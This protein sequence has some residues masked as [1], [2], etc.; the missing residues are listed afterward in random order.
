MPA[1]EALLKLSPAFG[2]GGA[3]AAGGGA[4][5]KDYEADFVL[6]QERCN[7][8]SLSTR[9]VSPLDTHVVQLFSGSFYRAEPNRSVMSI[10]LSVLLRICLSICLSVYFVSVCMSAC[11][12]ARADSLIAVLFPPAHLPGCLLFVSFL[13][14]SSLFFFRLRV[15]GSG[16]LTI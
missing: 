12:S 13:P 6:L 3:A 9:K 15:F 4:I 2:N 16:C 11:L 8:V 14:L 10:Y 1:L 5:G 7:D